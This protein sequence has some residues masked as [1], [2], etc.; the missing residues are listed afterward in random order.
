MDAIDNIYFI[1]MD[2]SVE[3]RRQIE[4]Q[5]KLF[6]KF[7][8]PFT[9]IPAVIGRS[10]TETQLAKHCTPFMKNFSTRAG[11]G[12]FLSHKR[13]WR[14]MIKNNERYALVL[15]DDCKLDKDCEQVLHTCLQELFQRDPDW[16]FL[17]GGYTG[18]YDN[19]NMSVLDYLLT[20]F[21][22][23]FTSHQNLDNFNNFKHTFI[24][25]C[26]LGTHCYVISLPFA[27]YLLQR[28]AKIECH[29]DIAIRRCRNKRIYGCLKQ[30]GYQTMEDSVIRDSVFPVTLHSIF[31]WIR[32]RNGI[33]YDTLLNYPVYEINGFQ[34]SYYLLLFLTMI[35][36]Y[37]GSFYVFVSILAAEMY[38]QPQNYR[39]ITSWFI[40]LAITYNLRKTLAI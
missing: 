21:E 39:L 19:K 27:K 30:I 7:Q 10:L 4:R 33:S 31:R 17:Y 34:V 26:P 15:E 12:C 1:N 38:I 8:K 23:P 9:R 5:Q 24:P 3:R 25:Y 18:V 37:P 35:L 11:I 2:S 22:K 6:A 29:V 13:V 36:L 16:D 40:S 28:F 14:R 32:D 20:C